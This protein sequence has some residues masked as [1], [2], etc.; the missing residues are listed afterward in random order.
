MCSRRKATQPCPASHSAESCFHSR[1]QVQS[2]ARPDRVPR[3]MF[4]ESQRVSKK[5]I[6]QQLQPRS[7]EKIPNQPKAFY[8]SLMFSANCASSEGS[9]REVT[10]ITT[11]HTLENRGD[12]LAAPIM[13]LA[14]IHLYQKQKVTPTCQSN[15]RQDRRK[16]RPHP[17]SASRLRQPR[18]DSS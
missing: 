15:I 3:R 4:R 8:Y 13:F 9:Q 18:Q 1:A 16:S 14:L 11:N 6:H 10:R 5:G 2:L 17:Q 7:T 12:L